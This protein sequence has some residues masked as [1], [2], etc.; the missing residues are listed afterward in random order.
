MLKKTYQKSFLFLVVLIFSFSMTAQCDVILRINGDEMHGRVVKINED[1]LQFVYKNESVE[2]TIDKSDIIKISFG[3]GRIEFFNK[4]LITSNFFDKIAFDTNTRLENYHNR[5]AVLPFGYIKDQDSINLM[6]TKSIQQEVFTIFKK[7]ASLLKFQNPELTNSI[8][9]EAGVKNNNI[10]GYTMGEI[11]NVLDVEYVIQGLVSSEK[12][13]RGNYSSNKPGL[14]GKQIYFDD[15]AILDN[16]SHIV[17][18]IWNSTKKAN[19]KT[20]PNLVNDNYSTNI[21]INIFNNK[22]DHVFSKDHASFWGADE[23]YK[24]TLNYLAKQTP[25]YK[26]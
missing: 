4:E 11:C 24:I 12:S 13:K 9:M 10:N 25:I 3:S 20:T 14:E 8:L 15:E 17:G 6:M 21:N 5:V 26:K 16:K 18:D 23:A 1:D 19:N 2:Y 22:G 7:N